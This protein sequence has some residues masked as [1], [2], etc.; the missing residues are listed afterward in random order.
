M[1]EFNLDLS[2]LRQLTAET[3]RRIYEAKVFELRRMQAMRQ[4]L[5]IFPKVSQVLAG[6]LHAIPHPRHR[7][8]TVQV[9]LLKFNGD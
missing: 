7:V 6:S 5:N 8:S 1:L 9:V 4:C 2:L 3:L